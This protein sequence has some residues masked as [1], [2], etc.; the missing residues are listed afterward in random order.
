MR[1]LVGIEVSKSIKS[2]NLGDVRPALGS[3]Q[4]GER[5]GQCISI[6]QPPD[7]ANLLGNVGT[8]VLSWEPL[9]IALKLYNLSDD[10]A[11]LQRAEFLLDDFAV[12][13]LVSPHRSVHGKRSIAQSKIL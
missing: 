13:C 6:Y 9:C 1:D 7:I 5:I 8:A 12:T 11:E 2:G 4:N 10:T 3:V